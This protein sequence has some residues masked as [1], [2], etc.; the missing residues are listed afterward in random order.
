MSVVATLAEDLGTSQPTIRRAI[1][2]GLI[3]AQR[4]SPRKV[5]VSVGEMV[6]LRDNWA[7]LTDLRTALRT[8]PSVERAV[9]FGSTARSGIA[10]ASDV[11]LAV[12]FRSQNPYRTID[13]QRRLND[14]LKR[15]I[16]VI[17]IENLAE[18][19]PMRSEIRRD[20]RVVVDRLKSRS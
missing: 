14:R 8:E 13:L 17:D 1:N 20:G 16:Q 12:V 15:R 10:S 3:R 11:D 2:V 18:P 9:L 4:T 5:H 19:N 6:Y 7:F